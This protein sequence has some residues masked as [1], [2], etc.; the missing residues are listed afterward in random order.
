MK[1]GVRRNPP[2]V[3]GC[4][5]LKPGGWNKHLGGTGILPVSCRKIY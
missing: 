5:L 2:K 4:I 1:R 3:K